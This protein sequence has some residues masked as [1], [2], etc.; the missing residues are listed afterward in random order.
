MT[1]FLF[2]TSYTVS[3]H[4]YGMK[5]HA[6]SIEQATEFAKLRNVGESIEM[7]CGPLDVR[8]SNIKGMKNLFFDWVQTGCLTPKDY[9]NLLHEACILSFFAMK[10]GVATPESTVGDRGLVHEIVHALSGIKDIFE[11]LRFRQGIYDKA[12]AMENAV[13]GWPKSETQ[14]TQT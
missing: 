3:G 1:V 8:Y 10:S 12:I 2:K 4:E 13:A 14:G 9:A 11:S 6:K 7:H 5:I